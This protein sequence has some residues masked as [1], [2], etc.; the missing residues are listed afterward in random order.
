MRSRNAS[1]GLHLIRAPDAPTLSPM[2]PF[3]LLSKS[4]DQV[5]SP[6]LWAR[7][8]KD[9]GLIAQ[10]D[11][12][13]AQRLLDLSRGFLADKRIH[14]GA[15]FE[16]E[17]WHQAVIASHCCLPILDLGQDWL[18][19]WS[20]VVLYPG[21]FRVRHETE[22]ELGLVATV[23]EVRTGEASDQGGP[24]VLAWSEIEQDL[25]DAFSGV[26]VIIH[27]IAHKL[28]MRNGKANGMPPL[29][30]GMS[31]KAWTEAFQSAYEDLRYRVQRN[32][33]TEIDPYAAEAPEEFFAVASE[34]YFSAPEVL[35]LAY[36]QVRA[37]F[38]AFY[39]PHLRLVA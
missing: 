21:E 29:H 9:A 35:G 15:E 19:G 2:F 24:V 26:N 36:P 33:P 11:D 6:A 17:P 28:D 25:D 39:H 4:T 23:D 12:E 27:E 37:Q 14:G 10:L 38:D 22:D 20:D 5:L 31:W 30:K 8:R 18:S 16:I 13:A 7:L 3:S 34:Y 1:A 32:W